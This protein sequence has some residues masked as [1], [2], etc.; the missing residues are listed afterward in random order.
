VHR[1]EVLELI[2]LQTPDRK[3]Y[4]RPIALVVPPQIN[5]FYVFDLSPERGAH[6]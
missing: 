6:I 3:I 5:K 1:N 2:Q 4:R